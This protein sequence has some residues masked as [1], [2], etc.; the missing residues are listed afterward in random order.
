MNFIK[1]VLYRVP[2]GEAVDIPLRHLAVFGVTRDSGKTTF[3]EAA[4]AASGLRAITFRTKRGE[5][6]FEGARQLQIFFDERG[7]THWRALEGLIA[8]TLEEKVQREPGIRGAIVRVCTRPTDAKSLEEV[9]DRVRLHMEDPKVRGFERDVFD[10][11]DAYLKEVLPQL[12]A[13]RDKFTETLELPEPGVYVEDLTGLSDEMQSLLLASVMKKVYEESS[14][15]IVVLPEVWKFL[16]QDR[17]SPVKWVIEKY[18]REMG[19]V[20]GYLWIDAQDLRGVDKKHLR[21]IDTRLFGRQPDPH[22]IDELLKALPLPKNVKPSPEQIMTLK[23]GHFYAK[24]RDTVELV[25]VRPRWLPENVA[26]QIAQ[27]A[28]APDGVEVERYKP[29]SK[30]L[31]VN[32]DLVYKEKFEEEKRKREELEKEFTRQV[33]RVSD[34]KADEKFNVFA[35]KFK[36]EFGQEMVKMESSLEVAENNLKKMEK[37]LEPFDKFIDALGDV[38][39]LLPT[40]VYTE[41]P[42]KL[43]TEIGVT[44]QPTLTEF[45]VKTAKR[46]Q[47]EATDQDAQGQIL[48]LASNGWFNEHRKITAVRAELERRFNSRPRPGTIEGIL[49]ELTGKGIFQREKE[50]NSWSYWLTPQ[51]SQ[52]IKVKQE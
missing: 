39:K 40:D 19:A 27:G 47:L 51:A 28:I 10:K 8:A 17:G 50:A 34:L 44:V 37:R 42:N 6:G 25:Y 15:V 32:N 35:G 43:P 20:E 7:L 45:T 52:L 41:V 31:E 5:I 14:G 13:L 3:I 18:V 30:V 16:P 22:E 26:V 2:S 11:L 49:A 48:L 38:L 36:E 1:N 21:S 9:H 12:R 29:D 33:E 4:V 24:L 46:E 23:L